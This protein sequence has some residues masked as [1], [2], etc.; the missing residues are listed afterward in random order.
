MKILGLSC[1]P[2]KSGNTAIL[3]NEALAGAKKEGAD[4]ELFSLSGK[5]IKPCDGCQA[6]VN[7]GKCHI[8]DDMQ[9]LYQKFIEADGIIFGTPVYFYAMASQAKAV[10]DRTYSLRRPTFRLVDKVGGVITVAGSLGRID[11]LKDLYFN[12]AINHMIPAD[13]IAATASEKGAIKSDEKT[14]KMAWELGREMVQL[15]KVGFEFP[16]EFRGRLSN[17]VTAKYKL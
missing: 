6:C 16:S 3:V 14:M 15:V 11:V 17:Y 12:I 7:T 4:A 5:E 2:R 1:S 9:T 10:I 8:K 13:Y